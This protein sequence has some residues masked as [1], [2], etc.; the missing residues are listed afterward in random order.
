MPAMVVKENEFAEKACQG[1]LKMNGICTVL[2]IVDE[3][4]EWNC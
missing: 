2:V 3:N 4:S 1:A